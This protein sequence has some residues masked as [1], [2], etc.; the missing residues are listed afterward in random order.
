MQQIHPI[1]STNPLAKCRSVTGR[2]KHRIWEPKLTPPPLLSDV[3][4]VFVNP[5]KPVNIG[6]V[7][8]A[9]SCFECV[10]LRIVNPTCDPL[11]RSAKQAA[12]G[13]QWLLWKASIHDSLASALE[14]SEL[15][16]AYTRWVKGLPSSFSS[17]SEL[18]RH[19]PF[20]VLPSSSQ[21]LSLVFGREDKGLR[22]EEVAACTASCS[23]PIGRLQES[24]SVSHCVSLALAPLYELRWREIG[25]DV[26]LEDVENYDA[27][28]SD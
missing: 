14:D 10:D 2:N 28:D 1:P 20:P 11:Q 25:D 4:V 15:S 26:G 17:T 8:R 27:D 22:P 3:S 9:C 6:A 16:I 5:K 7:A 19:H 18:L 12:K 24:L 23:I 13:A 21:R